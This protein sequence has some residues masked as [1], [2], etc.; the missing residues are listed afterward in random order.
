MHIALCAVATSLFLV[1]GLP[2]AHADT[3]FSNFGPEFARDQTTGVIVSGDEG[4][5]GERIAGL[6][7]TAGVTG[8]F[9][10]LWIAASAKD[11]GRPNDGLRL[12]LTSD[13]SDLPGDALESLVLNDVCYV[14][15]ECPNGQLYSLYAANT[16]ELVQG[17]TYWL[18]ATSDLAAADFTWYLTSEQNP[19]LVYLENGFVGTFPFNFPPALR[20]DVIADTGGGELPEPALPLLLA[21]LVVVGRVTRSLRR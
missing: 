20:I 15:F 2:L 5:F 10:R 9:D 1:L 14:D 7:F 19:G 6:Q 8:T 12:T 21:M 16:T 17:T 13:N 18:V 4:E 11:N 3:A